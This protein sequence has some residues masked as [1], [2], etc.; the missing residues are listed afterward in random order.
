VAQFERRGLGFRQLSEEFIRGRTDAS[1]A[2]LPFGI[3]PVPLAPFFGGHERVGA[4]TAHQ[5]LLLWCVGRP[6]FGWRAAPIAMLTHE[7]S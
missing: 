7:F 4:A 1:A 3:E 6:L 5:I 2:V